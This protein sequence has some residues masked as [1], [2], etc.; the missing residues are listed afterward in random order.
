MIFKAGDRFFNS[1]FIEIV[2]EL[3]D[4]IDPA[5]PEY[6]VLFI[7]GR[8]IKMF[9]LEEKPSSK[10]KI[11]WSHCPRDIFVSRWNKALKGELNV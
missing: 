7:S 5:Y 3:E 8:A 1:D 4:K 11:T 6:C 10:E 2:G 9:S